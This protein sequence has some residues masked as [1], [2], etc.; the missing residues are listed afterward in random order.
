MQIV[1]VHDGSLIEFHLSEVTFKKSFQLKIWFLPANRTHPIYT[2]RKKATR[3]G[4]AATKA[5]TCIPPP[6]LSHPN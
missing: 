6:Y 3:P 2:M 4:A 5:P 1:G